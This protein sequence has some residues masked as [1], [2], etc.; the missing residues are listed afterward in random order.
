LPDPLSSAKRALRRE[1]ARIRQALDPARARAAGVAVERAL[2]PLLLERP[3]ARVALYA[4]LP[5]ELPLSALFARLVWAGRE[6]LLPRIRG[7]DLEFAGA[8]S[9]S[10]LRPGP[11]GV[12]EPPACAPARALAPGDVVLLPGVAFDRAGQRL[13]RGGGF[14]DRA[15]RSARP[16]PLRI[17][18]AFAFQLRSEVPHASQ[19]R[20]VDAIVTECGMLWPRGRR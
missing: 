1:I 20:R 10:V 15:F 3:A 6:P 19:D 13:G 8:R 11:H 16:G 5:D 9:R 14:Y 12:L 2:W 17:G 18:V 7:A 4:A